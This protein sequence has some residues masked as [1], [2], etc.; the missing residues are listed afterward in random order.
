MNTISYSKLYCSHTWRENFTPTKLF[1]RVFQTLAIEA[2]DSVLFCS[3][4]LCL[5]WFSFGGFL[6]LFLLK[7][8]ATIS[9]AL[10][11]DL[12]SE[13]DYGN[14]GLAWTLHWLDAPSDT[15][16]AGVSTTSPLR[17]QQPAS[18]IQQELSIVRH[19][20]LDLILLFSGLA[21]VLGV[22]LGTG[23]FALFLAQDRPGPAR[24][25]VTADQ[26]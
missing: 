25:S 24:V 9:W 17:G 14:L 12:C 5:V 11:D 23:F 13:L 18:S 8:C 2:N 22:R 15:R 19:L 1:R 4:V 6:F 20:E 16:P 7:V 3:F 21:I 26:H 10:E